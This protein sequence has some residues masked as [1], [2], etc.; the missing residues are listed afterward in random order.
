MPLSI[1]LS[2]L[3]ITPGFFVV[4]VCYPMVVMAF[5]WWIKPKKKPSLRKACKAMALSG[6]IVISNDQPSK[7]FDFA[8]T[9]STV[10]PNFSM[11]VPPGAEA[12]KRFMVS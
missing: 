5:G 6:P 12:P 9:L 3:V 10:K 8:T 2:T 11:Q 4:L 7:A 1:T